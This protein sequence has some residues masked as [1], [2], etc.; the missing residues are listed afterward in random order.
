M[1]DRPVNLNRVRKARARDAAR[2][3]ADE[4]AVKHGRSKEEREA[5]AARLAMLKKRLDGHER[6]E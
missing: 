4:N 1:A 2:R 5:E 6:D 3:Q